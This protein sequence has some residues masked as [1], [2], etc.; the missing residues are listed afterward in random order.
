MKRYRFVIGLALSLVGL[1]IIIGAGAGKP[2]MGLPGWR[3]GIAPVHL[4]WMLGAVFCLLGLT[5]IM[6]ETFWRNPN[7]ER[8][9]RAEMAVR[10]EILETLHQTGLSQTELSELIVN[11]FGRTGLF[12]LNLDQLQQL[13]NNLVRRIDDPHT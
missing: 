7:R 5:L 6:K 1:A 13:H 3:A 12:G 2:A 8:I 11:L 10:R 9:E 4:A